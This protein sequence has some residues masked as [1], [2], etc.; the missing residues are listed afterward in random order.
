MEMT[1]NSMRGGE[2]PGGSAS[3]NNGE[4]SFGFALP[5]GPLLTPGAYVIAVSFFSVSEGAGDS[6]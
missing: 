6:I 2:A 5:P 1:L 4:V 3:R